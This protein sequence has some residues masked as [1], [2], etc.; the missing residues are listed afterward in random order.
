MRTFK[1]AL[2]GLAALG[3]AVVAAPEPAKAGSF[4]ISFGF[5]HSGYHGY[6]HHGYG[7]YPA[8]YGYY[9][10]PYVRKVVVHRPYYGGYGY[11]RVRHVGYGYPHYY[12]RP[13]VRRVVYRSYPRYYGYHQPYRVRYVGYGHSRHHGWRHHRRWW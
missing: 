2:A 4:G 12:H 11:H 5:G 3:A 13:I 1:L 7:Y 6:R 10:R 8:S 9:H